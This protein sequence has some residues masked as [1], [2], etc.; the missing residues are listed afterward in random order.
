MTGLDDPRL[1]A[2]ALGEGDEQVPAAVGASAELHS[3]VEDIREAAQLLSEA[4]ADEPAPALRPDQRDAIAKESHRGYRRPY[5]ARWAAGLAAAVVMAAGVQLYQL[6]RTETP[7]VLGQR[8]APAVVT[9]NSP[10]LRAAP[11]GSP[12][13]PKAFRFV[14]QE[15]LDK[16]TALGDV[17]V[18]GPAE[19][20]AGGVVGG[21]VGGLP[22]GTINGHTRTS[23]GYAYDGDVRRPSGEY[24][25]EAYAHRADNDFLAVEQNPLSTF[26]IDVDTASYSNV[27]RFLNEGRLPPPDAVRIEEMVNYFPYDY[28]PPQGDEPFAAHIEVA[29]APWRPEHRLVRIG[30]KTRELETRPD[31]NLVFLVDVSGSMD[32]PNKLPLVQQSLRLLVDKLTARD[33]VAMV[34]YAGNAG[35]V[36]PPTRGD[37]RAAILDAI[38]RL[39]AGGSTNGGEGLQLAYDLAARHFIRG[40]VNRVIL[41]TD[42]DFNVGI[43]DEGSLV[44]LIEQKAKTGV[45][46]SVFGFG[47]GNY[48]DSRLEILA[49]KGN[50]NYGYIDTLHEARKA[51]VEQT[52]A[53]LVTVAKDVKIQVEFNPA[54]VHSYRLIGYENR[55]LRAEDFK[56]DKKD[57]GEVGAGHAVTALYELVPTGAKSEEVRE[58]DAL[59]Y[60]Q[61]GGLTE[62]A[63]GGELLRLK[64]RYK[65][66]EGDKST[67]RE[68]PVDDRT[69]AL[70]Q[71]SADFRFAAAVA[72]LGL[73]LR[74]SPH[75]AKATFEDVLKLAESGRGQDRFG[76]RAELI[77]LV[78]KAKGL[79]RDQDAKAR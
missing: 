11:T 24:N 74:D 25:R 6:Q 28:A 40:G 5:A 19:G 7:P 26:S 50:G 52:N 4:L 61:K 21:V 78:H 2:H 67:P 75:K 36:L 68:W 47:M 59:A 43:S 53:T 70:D 44:R 72:E 12:S 76:Y 32:E 37:R 49:D 27:R 3:E 46:L 22:G 16:V 15:K 65:D 35:E 57:A 17:D 56:D 62:A 71:T 10:A 38:D 41:A 39:E 30:L 31:S 66:P 48:Q 14:S 51:L 45:F 42:G 13:K 69:T 58:V 34:V 73:L 77:T 20:V 33:R 18:A 64:L 63:R 9:V 1:T 8:P 23:V 55:L 79:R 54:K 60:Q 29:P